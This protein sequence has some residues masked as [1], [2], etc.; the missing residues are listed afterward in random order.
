MPILPPFMSVVFPLFGKPSSLDLALVFKSAPLIY[1]LLF[2]LSVSAMMIYLYGFF[3]S[4]SKQLM[5]RP[6][7]ER[8]KKAL[9]HRNDDLIVAL[10]KNKLTLFH[11]MILAGMETKA[12][13][14]QAIVEAMKTA[15]EKHTIGFWQKVSLLN[16]IAI[17][18]P[19]LGLLGTVSGMF[20]V[21]YDLNRSLESISILFDGLGISVGTTLAGLIVA[22][23]SMVLGVLL[24]HRFTR[25]LVEVEKEA[26]SHAAYL[27]YEPH[28]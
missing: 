28:S 24:K 14:H 6:D 5:V 15:G 3:T 19:M 12:F 9:A 16:D 25:L 13:G 26:L 8:V 20:S 7:Q 11:R 23:L 21:F 22:I 27:I 4:R 17:V 10:C 18:A 1:S 2:S